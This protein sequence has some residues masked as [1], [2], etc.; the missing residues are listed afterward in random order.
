MEQEKCDRKF[1]LP[2]VTLNTKQGTECTE[3]MRIFPLWLQIET[4][5]AIEWATLKSI[6]GSQKSKHD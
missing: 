1:G 4:H 5:I 2:C 6:K 3:D